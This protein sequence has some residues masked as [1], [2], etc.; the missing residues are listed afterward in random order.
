MLVFYAQHSHLRDSCV[1]MCVFQDPKLVL[2]PK[3]GIC[4]PFL[5]HLHKTPIITEGRSS[6]EERDRPGRNEIGEASYFLFCMWHF[7]FN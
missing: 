6:Q 3:Y 2:I 5:S 4:L 7:N 1:G